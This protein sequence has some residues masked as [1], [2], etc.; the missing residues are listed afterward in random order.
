MLFLFIVIVVVVI[1]IVII[2]IIVIIDIVDEP[3]IVRKKQRRAWRVKW[4]SFLR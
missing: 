4:L 3:L 2:V 1:I